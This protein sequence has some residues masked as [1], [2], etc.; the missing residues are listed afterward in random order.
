MYFDCRNNPG[1]RQDCF[2]DSQ[3]SI[4]FPKSVFITGFRTFGRAGNRFISTDD[5]GLSLRSP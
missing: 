3:L 5:I 1:S 4:L 2:T